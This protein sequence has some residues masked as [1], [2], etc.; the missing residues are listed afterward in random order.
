MSLEAI[1]Q[2]TSKVTTVTAAGGTTTDDYNRILDRWQDFGSQE[3][4]AQQQLN[5]A[6]LGNETPERIAELNALALA[7]LAGP[8]HQADVRNEVAAAVYPALLKESNSTADHNYETLRRKFNSTASDFMKAF[9]VAHPET[10]PANLLSADAKTRT[11]WATASVLAQDLTAQLHALTQAAQLAGIRIKS[12]DAQL[13]LT[14]TT[15][16]LH[17]RRVWEAWETQGRTNQWAAVLDAGAHIQAPALED[18]KP[19]RRP[20]PMETQMVREGIGYRPVDIDPED[21]DYANRKGLSTREVEK[22]VN[23]G[24]H[25][26]YTA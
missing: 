3:H 24:E 10:D 22:R 16:G 1:S 6:I 5:A 13:A 20:A 2:L 23:V 19:Y 11:A 7:E 17:R 9:K 18:Y 26:G 15:E 4:S 12:N 8:M 14:I 21:A 25:A